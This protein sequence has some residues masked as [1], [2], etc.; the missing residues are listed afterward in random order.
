MRRQSGAISRSQALDAG[1]TQQQ[2]RHLVRSGAWTRI[3]PGVYLAADAALTWQSWAH[4]AVLAA[5]ADA[6]L[7][8]AT[9]AQLR[10][11]CPASLPITI[12]IPRHRR[13]RIRSDA[14]HVLR[15]DVPDADRVTVDGLPT[16]TRLRTAVDVAHLL[17]PVQAQ[18]II[19]RMLVLDIVDLDELT[20]AIDSSRRRGSAQARAL[21]RSAADLA[22]AESERIA[23]RLFREAGITGWT[24][25]H[26]VQV[27]GGRT[28]KVDLALKRYT[29][30]VEVKGWL[31]HSKSDRAKADDDRI[32]DLQLAGWFVIPVGWL[33]LMT[34]PAGVVAKVRAAIAAREA[35][36]A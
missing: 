12:A 4:I 16:T 30:A 7:V 32:T 8:G 10:R 31:F 19:D 25:N 9:A 24:A 2:V 17:P 23:R 5:G 22:A 26:P 20:A 11:W 28:I 18:P 13:L 29:I 27:R 6:V 21:M 3:L 15:L 14:V 33:E 34:D 1:L 35:N 36:A